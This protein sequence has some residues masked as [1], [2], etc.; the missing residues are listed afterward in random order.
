MDINSMTPASGRILAEDGSE[1][2]VVDLLSNGSASPVSNA[3]Y[4]INAF[5]PRT[6]RV[7]GE[8]GRIYNLVDL[9]GFG[10]GTP[11]R[12]IVESLRMEATGDDII[13]I[14]KGSTLVK[15]NGGVLVFDS[16]RQIGAGNLD[17][18]SFIV[19]Q[20]YG[21]FITNNGDIVIS[22]L[23]T[24]TDSRKIGGFHY[25][26][27]RRS[28]AALQPINAAGAVKG[29]GWESN[30]YNGIVSHSVWTFLHRPKCS[31]NGMVYLSN[32]VWAD[33]Y[34]AS[35]DGAG[36]LA[37]M[38]NTLPLTGLSW[39][40]FTERMLISGKRLL[41]YQ[42]FIQAAMGSP[43]GTSGD[44]QNAWTSSTEAQY[45]G[46]VERAVSSVGCRDC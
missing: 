42:E 45:T 37:S 29:E 4:D 19:G 34:E 11:G 25:G 36:G 24:V 22:A 20:D 41:T 18:G 13:T 27:N 2:N 10:G 23:E 26:I 16:D 3:V 40:G 6:G 15:E 44:N 39:Y 46:F 12:V 43:P 17:N 9:L 14:F 35:D 30:I 33:I 7:I 1:V 38:H 31:P 5:T 28:N 8:D 21:V 32:G